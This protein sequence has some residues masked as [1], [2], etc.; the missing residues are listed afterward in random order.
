MMQKV[1]AGRV[2]DTGDMRLAVH[3]VWSK[4]LSHIKYAYMIVLIP[5]Q[6]NL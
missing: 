1:L 6:Y 4:T 2:L 5:L 3:V